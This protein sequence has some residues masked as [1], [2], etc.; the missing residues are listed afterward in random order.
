MLLRSIAARHPNFFHHL[1]SVPS[2]PVDA[3]P[4]GEVSL[5]GRALAV[6]TST[7]DALLSGGV[8]WAATVTAPNEIK[9]RLD[10]VIQNTRQLSYRDAV[11]VQL[12]FW[13]ARG[14]QLDTT[15]RQKG[16]RGVTRSLGTYL[17]GKHIRAVAD[18]FQN[19]GKNT[20]NLARG[21]VPEFDEV[22][23]WAADSARVPAEI[24]AAFRYT[25]AKI[26][27]NARPVLAMPVLNRGRLTFARVAEV[28]SR[29]F[30]T[31]SA[32][33][34]EQFAIAALLNAL[35]DQQ[36]QTS[37]RVET[38]N[39]NASDKSSRSAGD[40]QILVGNRLVEAI[41]VTANDWHEKLAGAAKTIKENDLGRLTIVASG[42]QASGEALFSELN[43]IDLD[44]AVLEVRT[45]A[46][47][48]VTA[49]TKQG[50]ELMFQRLYEFL[51]RYQPNVTVV[52]H[53][54]NTLTEL[55]LTE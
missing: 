28:L 1:A 2:D 37:Y 52:N 16:G 13:I 25:C 4:A 48:M 14:S 10:L 5:A 45:F 23:A 35:V 53:Y 29:L 11:V 51:D 24:E 36:G 41:E 22:L 18:A 49:L 46:F 27:A 55:G 47:S 50:R 21:N 34:Y 42:V 40:I 20:E 26:A 3:V 7:F 43:A 38:K 12:A 44:L 31:P 30:A 15:Q 39:L 9:E 33:A 32:G 8:Q 17:A 54:V 6:I 19:I